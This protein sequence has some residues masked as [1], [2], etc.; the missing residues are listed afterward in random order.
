MIPLQPSLQSRHL[1]VGCSRLNLP[2]AVRS[3]QIYK[4][5]EQQ[6]QGSGRQ[7]AGEE[8]SAGCCFFQEKKCRRKM[9]ETHVPQ[10]EFSHLAQSLLVHLCDNFIRMNCTEVTEVNH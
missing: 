4:H 9:A 1:H 6:R 10:G 7:K 3:P 2:M 5:P 8:N